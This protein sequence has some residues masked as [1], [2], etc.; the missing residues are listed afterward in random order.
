MEP[1]I[2]REAGRAPP[3]VLA[4]MSEKVTH[5]GRWRRGADDGDNGVAPLHHPRATGGDEGSW[6]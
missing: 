1:A 3:L 2:T 4:S 5:Q 6:A